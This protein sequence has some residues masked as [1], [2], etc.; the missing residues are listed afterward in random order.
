MVESRGES[1]LATLDSQSLKVVQY[2]I[3]VKEYLEL[4]IVVG[5]TRYIYATIKHA[6]MS[7]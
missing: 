1:F 3:D 7:I 6:G 2:Y 4:G 5:Y